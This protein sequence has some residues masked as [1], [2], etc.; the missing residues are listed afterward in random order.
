MSYRNVSNA[1]ILVG[2]SCVIAL[3][4]CSWLGEPEQVTPD[5]FDATET[6]V[7]KNRI[8][9]PEPYPP[10]ND[11][12]SHGGDP[13]Q[14]QY[15]ALDQIN[16]DNVFGL[17]PVWSY[18]PSGTEA[19]TVDHSGL[20][21]I[22]PLV[23][24][25]TLYG[26]SAARQIFA[27]D[28]VSGSERWR[29]DPAV[30]LQ[31]RGLTLPDTELQSSAHHGFSAWQSG[32]QTRLFF[33]LG[34]WLFAVDASNGEL[35]SDFGVDGLVDLRSGYDTVDEQVTVAGNAPPAVYRD[36]LIMGTRLAD[37]TGLSG[38][39]LA[40]DAV[41]GALRWRFDTIPSP[42]QGGSASWPDGS[43]R[44]AAGADIQAPITVDT[45]RG[46]AFVAVSSPANP[47]DGTARAGDNL[48]SNSLLALGASDGSL[49]W[50]FQFLRHDLW[51]RDLTAAPTLVTVD[52]GDSTIDAVAQTTPHG[53]VYVFDRANGNPLFDI[54]SAEAGAS[55]VPG[56]HPASTQPVPVA[57]PAL[58][59][60]KFDETDLT[61]ISPAARSHAA[62][63]YKRTQPSLGFTPL[64]PEPQVVM[65]G[66][67]GGATWGGAAWS[68][69]RRLL[70]VNTQNQPSI[71]QLGG[72]IR[73]T[74]P[75][76]MV[77]NSAC[78]GC[79]GVDRAGVD[80]TG[81]SLLGI[82]ERLDEAELRDVISNGRGSMLGMPIP[83]QFMDQLIVYLG[84]PAPAAVTSDDG[85]QQTAVV[86]YK[87]FVDHEG[88]PAVRPPWGTLTAIDLHR[89]RLAWQTILGEHKELSARRIPP[90]GTLNEGGP[91]A[92][93]GD[94]LFI[95][96]TLDSQLR[97]FDV[98]TGEL[99][100]QTRLP[101]PAFS[102]PAVYA[103]AGR[104]FVVVAC[105]GGKH[106]TPS[107][108]VYV[109]FALPDPTTDAEEDAD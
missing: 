7:I 30:I 72:R 13:G 57:P 19:Q 50:H 48:Y 49:R 16:T 70:I 83:E 103:V 17:Q 92:T 8:P 18:R 88:Y 40:F 63:I 68:A 23:L 96:A 84:Q 21:P 5:T 91:V 14:R 107:D 81:P 69:K 51:D 15:S 56:E 90:T 86:G 45:Q 79:H 66:A 62:E 2:L 52:R 99:L 20:P 41:S 104:Q 106:G 87:P 65:P 59:R 74:S 78:A 105:G 76:S 77:Y 31:A 73:D 38:R 1:R 34:S 24:H 22:N 35:L 71:G 98:N 60:V 58:A 4:A 42:G 28:A 44:T 101:A 55:P 64:G 37:D 108:D 53:Y 32:Q 26:I 29:M 54:E 97:A 43:L 27:V 11:W 67:N 36:L 25:G 47:F 85:D 3:G 89:G 100:W 61:D 46:L 9:A 82:S 95:A 109:A 102:T 33:S 39:V 75:E 94:V 10:S 12:G 93:A 6:P 80:G